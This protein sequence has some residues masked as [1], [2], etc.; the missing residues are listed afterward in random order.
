MLK[1]LCFERDKKRK[2]RL[3]EVPVLNSFITHDIQ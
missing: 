2:L 1:S 3:E